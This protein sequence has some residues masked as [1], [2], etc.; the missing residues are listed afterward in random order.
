M[1]ATWLKSLPKP[2]GLMTCYDTRDQQ[3]LDVCKQIGISAPMMS[4]SSASTTTSCSVNSPT[5]PSPA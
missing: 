3:I 2:T 1:I 4:A 5:L